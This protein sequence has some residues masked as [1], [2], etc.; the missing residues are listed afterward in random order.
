M[1]PAFLLGAL[2]A[3]APAQGERDFAISHLHA[4]R[5][6][7][8]DSIAGLSQAQWTFKPAP[9]RWSVAECAEHVVLTDEQIFGRLRRILQSPGAASGATRE[10][11]EQLYRSMLDRSRK[12]KNDEPTQPTGRW[13]TIAALASSFRE[14]RDR[15]IEYVR[16]TEENLRVRAA[17]SQSGSRDAYQLLVVMAAHTER[18]VAQIDEVKADPN[19]PR[20]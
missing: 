20:N 18:H 8:L 16:T 13:A 15:T 17:E 11:D 12:F 5:K 6:M 7:L 3:Q 2:W 14:E 4:T 1:G 9:D 19:F 10:Q